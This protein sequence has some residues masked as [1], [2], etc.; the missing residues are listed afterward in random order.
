MDPG[1]PGG[2]PAA[3][4]RPIART[5]WGRSVSSLG[6]W[7]VGLVLA[8]LLASQADVGGTEVVLVSM[9]FFTLLVAL[10]TFA[11][12]RPSARHH[13]IRHRRLTYATSFS[14]LLLSTLPAIALPLIATVLGYQARW[15][16]A[17]F[18][19]LAWLGVLVAV[20]A[21]SVP[22]WE[23]DQG[24]RQSEAAVSNNT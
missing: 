8:I 12:L 22:R 16:Q 17:L 21:L 13:L 6:L 18:A 15:L 14:G 11:A 3:E 23:R 9:A 19:A 5:S 1:A 24:G 20:T 2:Q 4:G 10:T 7:G